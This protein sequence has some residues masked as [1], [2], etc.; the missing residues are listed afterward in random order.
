[1]LWEDD[2]DALSFLIT[3]LRLAHACLGVPSLSI[4]GMPFLKREFEFFLSG[5]LRL[6]MGRSI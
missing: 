6:E 2:S 3:T 5:N 4:L 1:M